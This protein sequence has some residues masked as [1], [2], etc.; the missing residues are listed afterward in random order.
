L[1][2]HLDVVALSPT[3]ARIDIAYGAGDG[4]S[5]A[6][7]ALDEIACTSLV[8]ADFSGDARDDV[9]CTGDKNGW[10]EARADRTPMLQT[11]SLGNEHLRSPH[12]VDLNADGK[13][14]LIGY[15]HPEIVRMERVADDR[16]EPRLVSALRGARF[17]PMHVL[18]VDIDRDEMLDAVMLG[19][20]ESD[21][22]AVD[23]VIVRDVQKSAVISVS[24]QTTSLTDAPLLLSPALQ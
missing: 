6:T 23:L 21:Q 24:D 8:V 19:N 12:T 18:I 2:Q 1:D 10:I 17:S 20:N 16:F 15:V 9:V 7:V 5:V 11:L 3:D 13:L 14:D 22:S 4:T